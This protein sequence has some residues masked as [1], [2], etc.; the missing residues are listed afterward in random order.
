[1]VLQSTVWADRQHCEVDV[2]AGL[3]AMGS[4]CD[5]LHVWTV[6]SRAQANRLEAA[7]PTGTPVIWNVLGTK[8]ARQY[9]PTIDKRLGAARGWG[10]AWRVLR[11]L[12]GDGLMLIDDDVT[13]KP[14]MLTRLRRLAR[15]T[16]HG[17]ASGLTRCFDSRLP[18]FSFAPRA[19]I[20]DGELHAERG[21]RRVDAIG[22]F[23]LWLDD[24][25]FAAMRQGYQP[26]TETTDGRFLGHDLHLCEWLQAHNVRIILDPTE[27]VTHHVEVEPG[28]Y[29]RLTTS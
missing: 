15:A 20:T 12:D 22:T 18:V 4:E 10:Q 25:A 26:A 28:N 19:R 29:R 16:A 24:L 9:D 23:G 7:V 21:P 14:G 13:F 5:L 3:L 8:P 11:E 6:Y 27:H 1:M 2:L 17:A